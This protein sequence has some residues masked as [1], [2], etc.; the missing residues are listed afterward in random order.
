M[1]FSCGLSNYSASFFHLINHACF[2]AALFLASG[3]LIH[4]LNDSQD[5]REMGGLASKIP[6][7]YFTIVIAS[8][9]L[10][11]LPFFSGA[12]SKDLILEIGYLQATTL[13]RIAFIIGII[14]AF[15][16]AAYSVRLIFLVFLRK[17]KISKLKVYK[18]KNL[19]DV[20]NI[21]II[22]LVILILGSIFSG[23]FL[24]EIFNYTQLVLFKQAIFILDNNLQPTIY[25]C[26]PTT[27]K[28]VPAATSVFSIL[29]TTYIYYYKPLLINFLLV[30]KLGLKIYKFFMN[31]WYFDYLYD[32]IWV[33]GFIKI[34][35]T[36]YLT[37]DQGFI[38]LLGPRGLLHLF[39]KTSLYSR[40]FYKGNIYEYI[41]FIIGSL[42]LLI[43]LIA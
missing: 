36:V 29:I 2:K 10:A 35:F 11:G 16:T 37:I 43:F 12:Y 15:I 13:S 24:K 17:P 27:I 5:I 25:C 1:I 3:A 26:I 20:D 19:H 40:N 9:A 22:P 18:I 39:S 42:S 28:W 21:I 41:I 30:T 6:Y 33:L 14:A 31:A 32:K 4:S 38:E 7:I 8:L 34:A 23:S